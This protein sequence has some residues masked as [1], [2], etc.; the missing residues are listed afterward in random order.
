MKP[1][2]PLHSLHCQVLKAG[3]KTAIW[4]VPYARA[5]VE[6]SQFPGLRRLA[7][8]LPR[9]ATFGAQSTKVRADSDGRFTLVVPYAGWYDLRVNGNFEK[10]SLHV[11]GPTKCELFTNIPSSNDYIF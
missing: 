5:S 1:A 6:P 7:R 8:L 2:P 11:D 9:L 3:T 4:G 10:I